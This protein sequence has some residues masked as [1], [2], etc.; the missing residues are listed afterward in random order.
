MPKNG[1]FF[2]LELFIPHLVENGGFFWK[3]RFV[4]D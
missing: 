3:I 1:N 4:H 2:A